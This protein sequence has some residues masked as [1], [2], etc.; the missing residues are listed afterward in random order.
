VKFACREVEIYR[1]VIS[2][3]KITRCTS[4]SNLFFEW[5]STRFE[6]FL[7]P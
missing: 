5:I 2:Y 1:F 7:C 4:F 3:K 6:Q